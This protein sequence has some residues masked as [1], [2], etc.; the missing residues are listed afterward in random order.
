MVQTI[1]ALY[2]YSVSPTPPAEG[3]TQL[4]LG[5]F[6]KVDGGGGAFY[7]DSSSTA[8]DNGGTVILPTGHAGAGRWKRLYSGSINV[9]WFGALPYAIASAAAN[10]GI[11]K[12]IAAAT[13]GTLPGDVYIPKGDYRITYPI[14]VPRLDQFR[15]LTIRG[16]GPTITILSGQGLAESTP[17]MKFD[18]TS[19]IAI[20]SHSLVS[21]SAVPTG[22]V[23]SSTS[24]ER[25][26]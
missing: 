2:S 23:L 21:N 12:A 20:S 24:W 25:T 6:S 15:G 8:E 17:V 22:R 18:N 10:P 4:V 13:S 16:D 3:D 5:Y 11:Q 7:W 19:K 1:A 26:R 14:I 9:Q